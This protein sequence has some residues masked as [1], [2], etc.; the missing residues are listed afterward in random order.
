[1]NIG[2]KFLLFLL[3]CSCVRENQSETRFVSCMAF[4]LGLALGL[5]IYISFG[6]VLYFLFGLYN[7]FILFWLLKIQGSILNW[8]KKKEPSKFFSI[9]YITEVTFYFFEIR[10]WCKK[11]STSCC[12]LPSLQQ[13]YCFL[14]GIKFVNGSHQGLRTSV[15]RP[16][17]EMR[18]VK[19]NCLTL[20]VL[21]IYG[22]DLSEGNLTLTLFGVMFRLI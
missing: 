19:I 14:L 12:G 20:F 1:M 17:S 18:F 2:S 9:P 7:P 5:F 3:M 15:V 6:L 21:Y 4:G 22:T 8:G 10:I 11:N 16:V 13:V